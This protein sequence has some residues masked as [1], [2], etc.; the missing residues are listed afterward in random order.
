[1]ETKIVVIMQGELKVSLEDLNKKEIEIFK[2]K[3]K[4]QLKERI[5]EMLL[6]FEVIKVKI[7]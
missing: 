7:Q 6:G 4:E 3:L 1:M 5:E 2:K